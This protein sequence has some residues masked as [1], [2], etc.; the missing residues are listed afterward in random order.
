MG[1]LGNQQGVEA[2]YVLDTRGISAASAITDIARKR[3]AGMILMR[4]H[5]GQLAA[6]LIGSTARQVIRTADCPV[7]V[8][9]PART[10]LGL[11]EQHKIS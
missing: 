5:S 3:G 7:W 10:L 9:G 4:A 6:A 2:D 11:A 8:I 1:Q